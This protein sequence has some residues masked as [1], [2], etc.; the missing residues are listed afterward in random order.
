MSERD[1]SLDAIEARIGTAHEM[2]VA[3]CK[4]R[5]SEGSREWIMSIPARDDY[6]PDLVIGAALRDAQLLL[7]RLREPVPGE[8]IVQAEAE[9]GASSPMAEAIAFGRPRR[10]IK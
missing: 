10:P 8:V 7:A 1:T 6:D 2:V 5:G 9:V 4:P 3:L